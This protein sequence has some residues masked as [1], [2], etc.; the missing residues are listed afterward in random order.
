M[1]WQLV[2]ATPRLSCW[3]PVQFVRGRTLVSWHWR[4]EALRCAAVAGSRFVNEMNGLARWVPADATCA[5]AGPW[6]ASQANASLSFRGAFRNSV[7]IFVAA[8]L[9]NCFGW[10]RMHGS[11]PPT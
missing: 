1:L 2:Q 6:H 7:P 9:A 5:A 4:H 11:A 10:Q 3:L 8:K